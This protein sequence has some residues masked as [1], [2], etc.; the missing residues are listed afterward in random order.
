MIV[1]SDQADLAMVDLA[2]VDLLVPEDLLQVVLLAHVPGIVLAL[3]AA[4]LTNAD[5]HAQEK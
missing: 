5:L 3:Q 2:M 1:T 4:V